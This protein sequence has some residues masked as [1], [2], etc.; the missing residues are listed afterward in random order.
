MCFC[1]NSVVQVQEGQ[2]LAK[3]IFLLNLML[4][5]GGERKP[6]FLECDGYGR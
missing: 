5:T 6:L 1:L 4:N 3:H 2:S